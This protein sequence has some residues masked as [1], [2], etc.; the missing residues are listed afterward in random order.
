MACDS[1]QVICLVTSPP[2]QAFGSERL[3]N[4]LMFFI[5]WHVLNLVLIA[6]IS[7]T[8]ALQPQESVHSHVLPC[9]VVEHLS[10]ILEILRRQMAFLLQC[11]SDRV[12]MHLRIDA[13]TYG[14][15]FCSNGITHAEGILSETLFVSNLVSKSVFLR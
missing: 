15:H 10:K 4:N 3:R 12:L 13:R 5:K 11:D 9:I 2:K 7:A 6:F 8:K 1:G 14:D